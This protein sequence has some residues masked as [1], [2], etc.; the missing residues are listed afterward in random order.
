MYYIFASNDN[1]KKFDI[2]DKLHRN[3]KLTIIKT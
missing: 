3:Y 2:I 1:Q